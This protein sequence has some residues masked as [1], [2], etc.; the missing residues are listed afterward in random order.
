MSNNTETATRIEHLPEQS[1]FAL[2]V[3]DDLAAYADYSEVDGLRD[4]DHTV[5][6]ADFR[7]RGLAGLVVRHAL[8]ETREQ[9]LKI[10]TSCSYVEK[11][12]SE[13]PEYRH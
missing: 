1:R 4:F 5:T 11:F 10:G 6:E 8:D 7:G 12:V 2:F 9:G 3:G 13:H